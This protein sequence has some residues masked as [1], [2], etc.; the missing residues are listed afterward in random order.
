MGRLIDTSIFI[1][2]ER[3]RLD[4]E[5]HVAKHGTEN[6]FMSVVT[7]SE[8][9]HGVHRATPEFRP[10]R[11]ITIEGWIDSF[12]L[13]DI[14]LAVAR[15]HARISAELRSSGKLIGVQDQWIAATCLTYKLNLITANEREFGRVPNLAVEN[16]A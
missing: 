5:N 8:L 2:A 11:S 14:D 10:Q 6:L 1:E 3:G 13:L 7:A 9:L 16:W 12:M 4:L 15:T